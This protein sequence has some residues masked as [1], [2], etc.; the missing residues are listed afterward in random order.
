MSSSA[1]A[2]AKPKR[3]GQLH[4][5]RMQFI[6]RLMGF[7]AIRFDEVYYNMPRLTK[8]STQI[9]CLLQVLAETESASRRPG[10][11][12]PKESRPMKTGE[13][14]WFMRDSL[15]AVQHA[16]QTLCDRKVIQRRPAVRSDFGR[17]RG[18]ASLR[19]YFIY[20]AITA[21]WDSLP[22]VPGWIEDEDWHPED[23]EEV[24]PQLVA[25]SEE[26]AADEAE[27]QEAEETPDLFNE[28]VYL[29]AAGSEK[30]S[31]S[32]RVE[33]RR[34]SKPLDVPVPVER[35]RFRSDAAI[36]IDPVIQRGVLWVSVRM[37]SGQPAD[38]QKSG[39]SAQANNRRID[40]NY[41]T[42]KNASVAHKGLSS[43]TLRSFSTFADLARKAELP[44]SS[45]DWKE[46]GKLWEKLPTP[47]RIKALTG[48][49]QRI[50]CGEFADLAKD[51][52]SLPR[53]DRYLAKAMWERPLRPAKAVHQ[54]RSTQS[55]IDSALARMSKL[56]KKE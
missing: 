55:K 41:S 25:E 15:S 31:K 37:G 5:H 8:G 49:E 53:V 43:N 17:S 14:C 21:S 40:A 45:M 35:V 2:T 50:Q 27:D 12:P 46:A 19:G 33:A 16:L 18:P 3:T 28:P 30:E 22:S 32:I 34:A 54:Q 42:E 56:G 36:E 4:P 47:N 29:K 11:K 44:G 20:S 23:Y 13:F 26:A 38:G 7:L 52:L 9:W 51:G 48:I 10:T 1:T 24:G 6:R 39:N